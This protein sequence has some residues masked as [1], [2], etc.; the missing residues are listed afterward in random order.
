MLR[1]KVTDEVVSESVR[2]RGLLKVRLAHIDIPIPL[3]GSTWTSP[4]PAAVALCLASPETVQCP[5]C[6]FHI[7]EHRAPNSR[8]LVAS[9]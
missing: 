9:G 8:A 2:R 1:Q 5:S 4:H 6:R 7:G 3:A